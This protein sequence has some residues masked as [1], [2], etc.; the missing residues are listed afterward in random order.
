MSGHNDW[1]GKD[2]Y[3]I[4]GVDK[5]AN[6]GVIKKAYRKL[7]RQH[8]PDVDPAPEAQEKFKDISMA[9]DVL[10]DEAK[11]REYNQFK[12]QGGL[13]GSGR[14]ATTVAVDNALKDI[15]N[16]G[17]G[18]P[19]GQ[20]KHQGPMINAL[21]L[22]DRWSARLQERI[23]GQLQTLQSHEIGPYG[24]AGPLIKQM[25]APL[26]A[27]GLGQTDAEMIANTAVFDAAAA[28]QQTDVLTSVGGHS[29]YDAMALKT[30][31]DIM[32]ARTVPDVG[33]A[34]IT[35]DTKMPARQIASQVAKIMTTHHAGVISGKVGPG[36]MRDMPGVMD[37]GRVLVPLVQT[38][39]GVDQGTA[40]QLTFAG[41][42]L[43]KH[44]IDEAAPKAVPSSIN[45]FGTPT[46]D[47]PPSFSSN[48]FDTSAPF[49]DTPYRDEA[50]RIAS[51]YQNHEVPRLELD[52]DTPVV[53]LAAE[54][55]A[56][57]PGWGG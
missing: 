36:G 52:L 30:K 11:R 19:A 46:Y 3:E 14:S 8:H 20:Q 38:T 21:K 17:F 27:A 39:F 1:V 41:I 22:V 9:Y 12:E 24:K 57:R 13:N 4:L 44:Q 31:R 51:P 26:V 7:A 42:H 2:F 55:T 50:K 18:K 48:P 45:P 54:Q 5:T 29:T 35:A 37:I 6:D 28:M 10:S 33:M 53:N 40:G 25:A 16:A 15:I 32:S 34:A 47:S 49:S 23:P 43:A 56:G